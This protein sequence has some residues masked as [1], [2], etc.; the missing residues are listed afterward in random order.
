LADI[1]DAALSDPSGRVKKG[2][3]AAAL[4]EAAYRD[5]EAWAWLQR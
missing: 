1:L 3:A 5:D 4:A 2:E